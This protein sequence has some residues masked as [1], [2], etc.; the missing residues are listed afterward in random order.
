MSYQ[1]A[2]LTAFCCPGDKLYIRNN[3]KPLEAKFKALE[4]C[5]T[6]KLTRCRTKLA[7]FRHTLKSLRL[8]VCKMKS[9]RK[10]KSGKIEV[11][12]YNS[13]FWCLCVNVCTLFATTCKRIL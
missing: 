6:Q 1:M 4:V 13:K 10:S 11:T 12:I 2:T 9:Y 8:I 7:L 5:H 3:K